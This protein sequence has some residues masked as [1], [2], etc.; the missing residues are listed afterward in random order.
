MKSFKINN[1][2]YFAPYPETSVSVSKSV[3]FCSFS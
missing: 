2:V 1:L 3:L